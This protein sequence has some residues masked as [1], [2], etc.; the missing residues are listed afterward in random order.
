LI[1]TIDLLLEDFSRL[2][3]K[4]IFQKEMIISGKVKDITPLIEKSLSSKGLL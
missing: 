3:S 4:P 2:Y 1:K